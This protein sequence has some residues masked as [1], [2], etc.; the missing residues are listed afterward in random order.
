MKNQNQNNI[1]PGVDITEIPRIR[2]LLKKWGDKFLHRVFTERELGY[3]LGKAGTV[4]HLAGRFAAKESIIKILKTHV[5]P[6][7]RS[8]E[9]CR[10]ENGEPIVVL[11]DE[12]KEMAEEKSI[13]EIKI[14]ISHSKD[15]AVA[16]SIAQM[17]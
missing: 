6:S 2:K 14:S 5:S 1:I 3:C 16:F 4:S 10:G 9:I 12:A 11:N 15:F 7:L 8:I 17:K 13:K